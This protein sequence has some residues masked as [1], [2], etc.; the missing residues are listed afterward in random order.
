MVIFSFLAT[1]CNQL[2]V[3]LFN[4][5]HL[6]RL[7][8]QAMQKVHFSSVKILFKWSST[9]WFQ[10]SLIFLSGVSGRMWLELFKEIFS[11]E[12]H[13]TYN[14]FS[15]Y[16]PKS[17][18]PQSRSRSLPFYLRNISKSGRQFF[19]SFSSFLGFA[20]FYHLAHPIIKAFRKRAD[21]CMFSPFN[22]AF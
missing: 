19:V 21:Y 20:Y 14:S 16:G 2:T 15:I 1:S 11:L 13:L 6:T 17:F 12:T 9:R 8:N 10:I 18:G 7:A 5:K 4:C 3:G 22:K